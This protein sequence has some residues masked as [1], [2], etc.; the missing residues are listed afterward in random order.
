M[1]T[2]LT[3]FVLVFVLGSCVDNKDHEYAQTPILPKEVSVIYPQDSI[4]FVLVGYADSLLNSAYFYLQ[5]EPLFFNSE[6]TEDKSASIPVKLQLLGN[7]NMSLETWDWFIKGQPRII[8]EGFKYEYIPNDTIQ[9]VVAYRLLVGADCNKAMAG[10][11]ATCMKTFGKHKP[12]GNSMDWTVRNHTVCGPGNSYCLEKKRSV[13][14]IR[15]YKSTDCSDSTY[16]SVSIDRFTC[17]SRRHG[18]RPT[19]WLPF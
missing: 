17:N 16:Q 11:K 6:G 12:L 9:N 15:Y 3:M 5:D 14:M 18:A 10:F 1:K 2:I 13:G 7:L 19:F 4:A 8:E